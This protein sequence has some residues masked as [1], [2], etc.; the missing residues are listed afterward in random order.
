MADAWKL[1]EYEATS[2]EEACQI[3][4]NVHNMNDI[5]WNP[6]TLTYWGCKLYNNEKDDREVFG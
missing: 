4:I 1:G 5:N 2:F 3:A 6:T